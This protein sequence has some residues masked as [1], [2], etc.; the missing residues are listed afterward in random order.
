[1]A[2]KEVLVDQITIKKILVR[3]REKVGGDSPR[4]SDAEKEAIRKKHANDPKSTK[5]TQRLRDKMGGHR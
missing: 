1:V 2:I 3:N 4:T 5:R